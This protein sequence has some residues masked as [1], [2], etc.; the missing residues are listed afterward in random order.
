MIAKTIFFL[1]LFENP[2]SA[3]F[4]WGAPLTGMSLNTGFMSCRD[5]RDDKHLS[6][7]GRI[8]S[9]CYADEIA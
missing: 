7:N 4:V 1:N 6:S 9:Q 5:Y 3:G 2:A 8:T